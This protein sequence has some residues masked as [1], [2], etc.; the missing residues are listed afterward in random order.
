MITCVTRRRA[1]HSFTLVF[2]G[3]HKR[4]EE[5][6]ERKKIVDKFKVNRKLQLVFFLFSLAHVGVEWLLAWIYFWKLFFF[7][8]LLEWGKPTSQ[9]NLSSTTLVGVHRVK[10]VNKIAKNRARHEEVPSSM[11]KK[12]I[13]H[14]GDRKN[15]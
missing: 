6:N 11:R 13:I 15:K 4:C 1:K 5:M 3:G 2:F 10:I 9:F 14:S 12:I 8:A 7:I